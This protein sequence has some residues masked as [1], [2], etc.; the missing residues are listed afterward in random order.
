[1]RRKQNSK[2]RRQ[3]QQ[4]EGK[5]DLGRGTGTRKTEERHQR[6]ETKIILSKVD[7]QGKGQRE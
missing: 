3:K 5:T 7:N 4:L 2:G 1:M 6:L